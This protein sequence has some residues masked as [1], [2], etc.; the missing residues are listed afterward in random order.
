MDSIFWIFAA[1]LALAA[2]LVLVFRRR[3]GRSVSPRQGT[4]RAESCRPANIERQAAPS[5]DWR[6]HLDLARELRRSAEDLERLG[7]TMEARLRAER[8]AG[9]VM[10]LIGDGRVDLAQ[11][12]D[13]IV[14][15]GNR[16]QDADPVLAE[17][18]ALEPQG[19]SLPPARRALALARLRAA[20]RFGALGRWGE[21]EHQAHEAEYLVMGDSD[22]EEILAEARTMAAGA[23]AKSGVP[24]LSQ[25]LAK[26][27]QEQ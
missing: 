17:V 18:R 25:A 9:I 22:A 8:A 12:L 20:E 26:L 27:R 14:K 23:R 21:A 15:L 19:S 1:S 16:L 24:T 4:E 2:A 3:A 10:D 13:D 11:E 6:A 5:N 7:N